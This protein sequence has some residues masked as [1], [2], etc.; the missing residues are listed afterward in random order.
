MA[1]DY[2]WNKA[3]WEVNQEGR[4]VKISPFTA[5]I[6]AVVLGGLFVV[7][8]P[9]IGLALFAKHLAAKAV[10]LVKPLFQT[11]VVPL[12]APGEAHLTGSPGKGHEESMD[13]TLD[14]LAKEIQDRREQD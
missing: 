7:F 10:S 14:G 13:E 11:S 3:K 9:F 8:L 12:A 4:G 6:A 2:Y 5:M 1:N